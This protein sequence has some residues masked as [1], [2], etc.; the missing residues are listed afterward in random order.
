M[1]V[2]FLKRF[3]NIGDTVGVPDGRSGTLIRLENGVA[4]VLFFTIGRVHDEAF[5]QSDLSTGG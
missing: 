3:M 5:N 2:I 4:T 1:V